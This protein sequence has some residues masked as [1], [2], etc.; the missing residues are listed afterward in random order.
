MVPSLSQIIIVSSRKTDKAAVIASNAS[1]LHFICTQI[2]LDPSATMGTPFVT[3]I[4]STV[5]LLL[6]NL[7]SRLL[8]LSSKVRRL[9]TNRSNTFKIISGIKHN[10]KSTKSPSFGSINKLLK[11]VLKSVK[12]S[13]RGFSSLPRTPYLCKMTIFGDRLQLISDITVEITQT[14]GP[15]AFP[16]PAE[17]KQG[18]NSG[19]GRNA[20]GEDGQH[21]IRLS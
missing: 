12:S 4:T 8:S 10:R 18:D 11:I 16:S 7:I 14:C 1:S 5:L 6:S 2:Y 17:D 3:L 21:S 15:A 9:Q 13:L 19:Q 20:A